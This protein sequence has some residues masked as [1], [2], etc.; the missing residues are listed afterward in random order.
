MSNRPNDLFLLSMVINDQKKKQPLNENI[1]ILDYGCGLG[2]LVELGTKMLLN[3]YGVDTFET[4]YESWKKNIPKEISEKISKIENNKTKYKD[5]TFD[6]IVSNHVFE[7]IKNP[8]QSFKEISRILKPDG[9]LFIIFPNKSVWHEGH[10][11]LFFP[12]WFKKHSYLQ[13]KYLTICYYLGLG[14]KRH[15]KIDGWNYIL[16]DVTFYHS[17]SSIEKMIIEAFRNKPQNISFKYMK[18]RISISKIKKLYP[19]AKYFFIKWILLFIAKKKVGSIFKIINL[20][21]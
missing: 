12:H 18:F 19:F 9:V 15:L 13:K 11:G 2:Q 20:N 6:Y 8:L 17:I 21:N 14:K 10:I 7:H 4:Y 16:N 5:N 1:K 3:I